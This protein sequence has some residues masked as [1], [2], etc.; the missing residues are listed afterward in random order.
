MKLLFNADDF[1]I[2]PG[3]NNGIIEAFTHGVVRSTTLMTNL[4]DTTLEAIALAKSYPKLDIG[5]H[6]NMFLGPSLTGFIAGCTDETGQFFKWI[7]SPNDTPK[8]PVDWAALKRE[9]IVQIEFAF[10][11]DLTPT[12]LD[13][14]RHGHLHPELLPFICEIAEQYN[15]K[16]RSYDVPTAYQ[17][18]M[19]TADF[20]ADFYDHQ[21]SLEQLKHFISTA[22]VD[23][24]EFMCHPAYVD[25]I[26]MQRSS[27]LAIREKEL[28]ILT[29]KTFIQWLSNNHHQLISFQN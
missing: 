8:I 11:H 15:L 19:V 17:H 10:D 14:H 7:Q 24:L 20:S 22:N 16:L 3:V 25:D 18:L 28:A 27:Y 12:H 23:S 26:L 29:D 6:L 13:S 9:L 5:I 1:G 4:G 2:S 21:V